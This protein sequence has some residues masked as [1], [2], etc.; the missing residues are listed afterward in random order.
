MRKTLE[1]NGG[2]AKYTS[3]TVSKDQAVPTA[4]YNTLL[5]Q[6]RNADFFNLQESYDKGGVADDTFY[7]ITVND[8][9]RARTVKVAQVGG[10]DVTPKPLQHL[11]SQL[12]NIQTGME[13]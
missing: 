8:G 6:I 12:T 3:G 7:S 13:K 10:K 11:I 4:V 5:Q 2:K 1:I 9:S